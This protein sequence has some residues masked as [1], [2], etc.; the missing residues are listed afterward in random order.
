MGG[1]YLGEKS[2]EALFWGCPSTEAES[3]SGL[4]EVTRER[5]EYISIIKAI[6][7]GNVSDPAKLCKGVMKGVKT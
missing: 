3:P 5:D 1:E 7:D 2:K 4:A 6:A